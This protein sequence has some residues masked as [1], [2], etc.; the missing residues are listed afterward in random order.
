MPDAAEFPVTTS[1]ETLLLLSKAAVKC[2]EVSWSRCDDL[3]L[4][5]FLLKALGSSDDIFLKPGKA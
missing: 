2:D 3:K 4:V 5:D 1:R